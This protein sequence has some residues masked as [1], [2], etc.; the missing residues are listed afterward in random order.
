VIMGTLMV[1]PVEESLVYVQPLYLRAESVRIPELR[2]VIVAA[3]DR[4]AME[5]TLEAS[6]ARIFGEAPAGDLKS[7]I[8]DAKPGETPP[9]TQAAAPVANLADQLKQHFDR[10]MQAQREGDWARY[11][12]EIKRLGAVIEQAQKSKQQ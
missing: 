2:R 3:G 4:I 10:A 7:P 6:L 8:P 1:I 9:K 5:P 11:G 12:E